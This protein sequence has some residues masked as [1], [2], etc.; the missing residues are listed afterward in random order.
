MKIHRLFPLVFWLG[1]LAFGQASPDYSRE[2]FVIEQLTRR[3]EF[4]NNGTG[5]V[6]NTARVQVKSEAGVRTFGQLIFG[7]NSANERLDI[8]YVRVRKVDGQVLVANADA[9]QDL[10][11]PVT[12]VA[13]IYTDYRQKHVTVPGLRPGDTLEYSVRTTI[14][15][16]VAPG[17]FWLAH[18]FDHNSIVLNERL[19]LS[20]PR[21]RA[22]KVKTAPGNDAAISEEGGRRVYVWTSS[23]KVREEEDQAGKK[24][25][26]KKK[27]EAD[28]QVTTFASWEEVGAWYAGL[29]RDRRAP[30]AEVKNKA[31]ELTKGLNT[32][33]ERLEAIYDYV[34]KN[35]RYVGLSF[36]VGRYQP[37]PA[38]E[39]LA[40]QYGDCKDKHTLLAAL[41]E[42]AGLHTS[43]VL[44]PSSRK[45]DPDV[46]SPAQFDHVISLVAVGKENVWLDTTTE[47]A[48]FRLL[49]SQ[50]RKKQALVVPESG[51][52]R[53]V[54]TPAD[55]PFPARQTVDVEGT[56][57]S[58][59][60][61]TLHVRESL[62]GDAE[63][64]ARMAFRRVPETQWKEFLKRVANA[65]YGE[66]E[67]SDFKI[68]DPAATRE[69]YQVELQL[70]RAGFLDWSR[71][72]LAVELPLA[73]LRLP[74]ADEDTED[75]IE[76]GSATEIAEHLKLELP[77]NY[78]VR[79]PVPV[80]VKRDYA[81]Y[82]SAYRLEG[83]TLIADRV[84]TM[85]ERELPAAR[86][87]DYLAFRRAVLSDTA[88]KLTLETSATGTAASTAKMS[89]KELVEAGTAALNNGN[90]KAAV[91]MLKRALELEPKHNSAWNNLGNAYF[92]L[93]Q[94][95]DATAAYRKHIEIN[96]YDA[97]VYN[98]LGLL[99]W[100]IQKYD[101]AIASFKKQIDVN[102]L[103]RPAHHNLGALYVERHRWAEAAPEL[104]KAA[105]LDPNNANIQAQLGRVYL[106]LGHDEKAMATFA[107]AAELGPN[108]NV[109][110]TIAYSLSM[111]NSHLDRAQQY[112]ESA[113]ASVSAVTRN[114]SLD[115]L[116][117][118]DLGLVD[119]LSSSW[120][121][122]GWILHQRGQ[123][124]RGERFIR[125]AWIVSQHGEAGDH[126]GQVYE[127]RGQK[128]K[129]AQIYAQ[130]LA[131]SRPIPET[132]GRLAALVGESQVDALVERA[133]GE[134]IAMR[135]L[136]LANAARLDAQAD[137]LILLSTGKSQDVKFVS[138]DKKLRAAA[139]ILRSANYGL[140]FPD[141]AAARVLRRGRLSCT[142]A[143]E[144]ALVLD[145]P[146]NVTSIE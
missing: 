1:A 70:T 21:E 68:G 142:A 44:I 137:F 2:P 132:R 103:D 47:V 130:A 80:T 133:R 138:G 73:T 105:S 76:F 35:V 101:D 97:Y 30:T 57:G 118:Q 131:A 58:V 14:E 100:R 51:P 109:W 79:L 23:N 145:V 59:G 72:D 20:V 54:E 38:A 86:V 125:A 75:P 110:N 18:N 19:E 37:H 90:Y 88:Q 3:A 40:N 66:S 39:V 34:A 111:N 102:P 123:A 108:P 117:Q 120:D 122:L 98:N 9:V 115:T 50:L 8:A 104:E 84:I 41:A 71:K 126:L 143:G 56:I 83:R 135:T 113:V 52:A 63:L 96:P 106:N 62:R 78:Q 81:E 11:S 5:T 107:R 93:H 94:Y 17:Q 127:G 116:R 22:I 129:A 74:N 27:E 32:D 139:D 10:T 46:P 99:F 61:L 43:A 134:L 144:C 91:D 128:Q 65:D 53:L 67:V 48:P 45:L 33:I 124:D 95:D 31:A 92:G 114:L 12:R 82:R 29:E 141:A 26:K 77:E 13:P 119:M 42:A 4:Q 49:A 28:V 87:G 24:K 15:T 89:A 69:P 16:P 121:T 64:S 6:V 55:P 112:A 7:Y 25:K 140:D 146:E 85:R 60:K 136:E 36:G